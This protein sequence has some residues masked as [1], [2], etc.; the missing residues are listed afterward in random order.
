MKK[1]S[2]IAV[3]AGAQYARTIINVGLSFYST[4]I[5]FEALGDSNYGIYTLVAGVVFLLSFVS[6]AMS[7]ST[8]RF[9]SYHQGNANIRELRKIFAN[10]MLLHYALAAS[11]VIILEIAGLFIFNGFLNIAPDRIYAAKFTYQ[12]VILMVIITCLASPFRG[13]LISHQNLIYTSFVDVSD[14]ILKLVIAFI[15]LRCHFITDS[16][17]E[18]SLLLI[19]VNLFNLL[20]YSLYGRNKYA[21][22]R[23]PKLSLW[24]SSITK[25]MVSFT[26]WIVYSTL[27]I[28]GR[29]QGTAII[30][31]KFYGTVANAAFGIAAQINSACTFVSG[32]ILNAFYPQIITS[33]GEG[34]SQDALKYAITSSK[35]CYLMMLMVVVPLCFY[36]NQIMEIWLGSVPE[37]AVPMARIVLLTSLSDQITKGLSVINKAVGK[38]KVYSLTVDTIKILTLPVLFIL[39]L[40]GIDLKIAFSCYFFMEALSALTRLPIM[41]KQAGISIKKWV[42]D[43]FINLIT[44][45]ILIAVFYF[46]CY[47]Y[48]SHSLMTILLVSIFGCLFLTTTSYFLAMSDSERHTINEMIKNLVTKIRR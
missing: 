48:L 15:V 19:T 26:G 32:S 46:L 37:Y 7:T 24:D 33:E 6:N 21:E 40:L 41:K 5:I 18:Y 4:R 34:K 31:N 13:L 36:M 12:C 28:M 2:L 43:V 35:L 27:M 22:C 17:I 9:L 3:N 30:I 39:L 8:Q 23:F 16:L 38:L 45:T 14:G 10:S 47:Y 44:P 29:N 1:N 11:F 25:K 42:M 20:A